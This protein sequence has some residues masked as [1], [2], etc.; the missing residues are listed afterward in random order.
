MS[1]RTALTRL[2]IAAA[3]SALVIGAASPALAGDD[4]GHHDGRDHKLY[5]GVVTAPGG[6]NLRD[7][8]TRRSAVVGFLDYG[9]KVS[10]FCK[11]SGENV[12]GNHLWYL[13]ADG[14]WAWATA[15][16]IDNIGPVPRWC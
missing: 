7:R 4:W 5:K 11:T 14:T 6:I 8:P 9:Q 15:R 2:G 10:I 1:L 13:L 3:G 16:F 12:K